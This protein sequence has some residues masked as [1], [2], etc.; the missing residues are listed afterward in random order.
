MRACLLTLGFAL[1]STGTALAGGRPTKAPPAPKLGSVPEDRAAMDRVPVLQHLAASLPEASEKTLEAVLDKNGPLFVTAPDPTP[2]FKREAAAD[3]GPTSGTPLRVLTYNVAL[4]D[5][6]YLLGLQRVRM[7]NVPARRADLPKYLFKDGWDV[8]LLQEVWDW[9]DVVRLAEAAEREGYVWYAGSK[10]RHKQHGLMILVRGTLIEGAQ[11]RTEGQFENQRSI[12]RW[13]GPNIKRGYITWTFTHAP[14]G[15]RLRVASAH[16][17]SWANQWRTRS[18][19]A[20]QLGLDLGSTPADTIVLLGTDLNAGPYY[21]DDIY[22]E[23]DGEPVGEWWQNAL[24]W[25]VIQHYGHL[26]DI[27]VVG[28]DLGDV[29]AM[30]ALPEWNRG[31]LKRPMNGDCRIVP[32]DVFTGTDCNHLYFESYAAQE[33]PAR[34]DH[35]FLRAPDGRVGIASTGLAYVEPVEVRGQKMELS[36]HYGVQAQ[37]ILTAP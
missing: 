23:I 6:G 33:Y 34:L 8:L 1:W 26:R 31:W 28:H 35:L 20:R 15:N 21:P 37:L 14:T 36:D 12:E 7:P 19:Q 9:S 11:E 13:P 22:G 32:P 10:R 29:P 3:R 24:T 18:L 4:L 16:P 2:H 30:H 5:R 27:R 25:P 17:Q